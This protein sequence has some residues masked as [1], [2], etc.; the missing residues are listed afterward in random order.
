[1]RG[2]RRGEEREDSLFK[3]KGAGFLPRPTDDTLLLRLLLGAAADDELVTLEL[4]STRFHTQC[5]FAPRRL[6]MLQS[7][8]RVSLASSVRVID[9]VHG[10]T[11]H[12]RLLPE[13]AIA[14]GLPDGDEMVIGIADRSDGC[15]TNRADLAHL[16]TGQLHD[17]IRN[18]E[19]DQNGAGSRGAD[20]LSSA[21]GLQL[22]VVDAI[23]DRHMLQT[24]AVAG[25]HLRAIG[26]DD[27]IVN[28][29]SLGSQHITLLAVAVVHQRNVGG[30]IGIVLDGGDAPDHTLLVD[31]LEIHEAQETLVSSAAMTDG[32][33][34]KIIPAGNPLFTRHKTLLRPLLGET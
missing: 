13:P 18:V 9:C 21:A 20:D 15:E 26:T 5:G 17:S 16:A 33:A 3:N 32:D 24:H 14:T 27:L 8:G 1:M 23:P 2:L 10:L 29:E 28:L 6:G 19:A 4:G 7:D 12:L 11:E 31:L 30:T 34:T 22:D 25:L